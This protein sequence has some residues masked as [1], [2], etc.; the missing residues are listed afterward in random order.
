MYLRIYVRII[1]IYVH[2][3]TNMCTCIHIYIY[4]HVCTN[5]C[6]CVYIRGVQL[7]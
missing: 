2:V 7:N 3:C 5:I 6:T 1:F 4:I